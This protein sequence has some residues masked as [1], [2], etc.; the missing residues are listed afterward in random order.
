MPEITNENWHYWLEVL[1]K[2]E[3]WSEEIDLPVDRELT[4]I[5]FA[6]EDYGEE[7]RRAELSQEE[8][9]KE[10]E[11]ALIRQEIALLKEQQ[12]ELLENNEK[13]RRKAANKEK[14]ARE[15]RRKHVDAMSFR[16]SG[17]YGSSK[18]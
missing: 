7:L 15:R 5:L 6:L 8:L 17:S 14:R 12:D 1:Q 3:R 4:Q 18:R 2:F 10:D 11:E 13:K 16:V 9:E